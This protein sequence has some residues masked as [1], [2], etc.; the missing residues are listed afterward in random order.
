MRDLLN[1]KK[2]ILH[3]T[4]Q[5]IE[6]DVE[7][8]FNFAFAD[9]LDKFERGDK[10]RFKEVSNQEDVTLKATMSKYLKSETALKASLIKPVDILC[11]IF[12]SGNYYKPS[13]DTIQ[14]SFN[15]SA[16]DVLYDGNLN[17]V[18]ENQ[19]RQL[20]NEITDFRIKASISHELSHWISD[21][22]NNSHL[23]KILFKAQEF[24]NADLRNLG[25]NDVNMTYFEIDAQIHGLLPI[26][27]KYK[28]RWDFLS[29][30]DVF[31]MYPSL[32]NI[33]STVTNKYGL[34]VSKIWQKALIQRMHREGILGKRMRNFVKY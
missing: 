30:S 33:N 18:P 8:I 10:P 13:A 20:K 34:E 9:F 7:Y 2:L 29:L 21:T 12:R 17:N 4:V 26:Y 16:L 22:L 32:N 15:M 11:G 31:E 14:I 27:K 25:K 5:S 1:E 6:E 23:S 3:E 24:N 19:Q 28:D